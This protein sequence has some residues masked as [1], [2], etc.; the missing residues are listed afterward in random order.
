MIH[1]TSQLRVLYMIQLEITGWDIM[2]LVV[3]AHRRNSSVMSDI[4]D[5]IL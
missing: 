3:C 4:D 1:G 5:Y 2:E